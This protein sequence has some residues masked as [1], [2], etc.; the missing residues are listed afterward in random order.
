MED[1]RSIVSVFIDE[2]GSTVL[3]SY[4]GGNPFYVS[5]AVVVP[6]CNVEAVTSQLNEISADF[7]NGQ[8][9]KSTS[10]G[11]NDER[12][13]KLLDKLKDLDFQCF[14]LAT[15][16]SK[17]SES[18]GLRYRRVYYKNV[19]RRL[20]EM[21]RSA[22]SG[23]VDFYVDNAAGN[24]EFQ[25][26]CKKYFANQSDFFRRVGRY[27]FVNDHDFRLVQL[28]DIVAGTM[29]MFF[30]RNDVG[31]R[32]QVLAKLWPKCN[33][34]DIFPRHDALPIGYVAKERSAEDVRIWQVMMDKAWDFVQMNCDSENDDIRIQ[35]ETL[36]RLIEAEQFDQGYIFADKLREQVGVINDKVMSRK[37]YLSRIIGG[38]RRLGIV[39]A[40]TRN[41]YKLATRE[42]DVVDYLN[43]DCMVIEPML[44]RLTSARRMIRTDLGFD[45][46]EKYKMPSLKAI[47]DA[48]DLQNVG[49][50]GSPS[51]DDPAVD[52]ER[53]L[54]GGV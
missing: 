27:E 37:A 17:L 34:V 6:T 24:E 52:D 4:D 23:V 8:P 42:K 9:F 11:Q 49:I 14:V 33:V 46:L 22:S 20:Y 31:L 51:M 26:S 29:R 48:M 25:E 15:D 18:E 32:R 40:G 3:K 16:K 44:S 5:A 30:H 28:A 13:F 21:I 50:V 39:I 38:I 2:S 36:K 35:C 12:R 19:N 47:V 41:G 7:N 45:V 1:L 10:I 53:A 54:V 43:H